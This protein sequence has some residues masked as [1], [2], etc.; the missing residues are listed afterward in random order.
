MMCPVRAVWC[1]ALFSVCL[2][3]PSLSS[4]SVFSAVTSMTASSTL[5][6]YAIPILTRLVY[7]E[8]FMTK[9]GPF[10]LGYLSRPIAT[11]ALGWITFIS[12]ILCIPTQTPVNGSNFN[13]A[14]V[15]VTAI[16]VWATLTWPIG[17]KLFTGPAKGTILLS[18][19]GH[20]C[21]S[22]ETQPVK[23]EK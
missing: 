8:H 1:N 6:S 23:G 14:P 13:Y 16:V 21:S 20:F 10:N 11:V 12:T 19:H 9:R 7:H 3:L 18:D 4:A 15:A 5:I 2:T 22:P 17:R